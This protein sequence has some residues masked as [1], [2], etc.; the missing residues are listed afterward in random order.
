MPTRALEDLLMGWFPDMFWLF[1]EWSLWL[2]LALAIGVGLGWML[3]RRR[4]RAEVAR[5]AAE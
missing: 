3:W 1:L 4:W 2:S 5:S